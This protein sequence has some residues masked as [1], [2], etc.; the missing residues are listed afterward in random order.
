MKD[1]EHVITLEYV[2][3]KLRE[4]IY[5]LHIL[6]TSVVLGLLEEGAEEVN[7]MG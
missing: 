4:H 5:Y 3:Q 2:L 6:F 7:G 1:E